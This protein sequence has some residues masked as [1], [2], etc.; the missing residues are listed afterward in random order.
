[1][2]EPARAD[3][4]V[5]FGR[6]PV[7][8]VRASGGDARVGRVSRVE[9]GKADRI[10]RRLE[11]DPLLVA[12]PADIGPGVAE[13]HGVGLQVADQLPGVLP[14]VVG[15]A[16]DP[17]ALARAAVE[18]VAAVGAVEPHLE[19]RS[20]LRQQLAQLLPVVLDVRRTSVL[21]MVAIPRRQVDAELQSHLAARAREV[22]DD[23]SAAVLPGT[24]LD[25]VIGKTA[26]PEREP[27]MMLRGEDQPLHP[28]IAR[29]RRPLPRIERRRI[30]G[31]LRFVAVAPL[32]VGERVDREVDEAVEL[33]LVPGELARCRDG[34]PRRRRKD[35]RLRRQDDARQAEGERAAQPHG[36]E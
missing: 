3:R 26:R 31:G 30:E 16:V 5:D 8:P 35:A 29:H 27:V 20:V 28:G 33:E 19:E 12:D 15:R 23:V 6:H 10:P 17:A 22:A 2:V 4:D 24:A 7:G 14:V 13:H 36:R 34:E 9:A 18:T 21:G 25:R 32:L 1:M 11:R